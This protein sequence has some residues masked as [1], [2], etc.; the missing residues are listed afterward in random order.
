MRETLYEHG[1]KLVVIKAGFDAYVRYEY[2]NSE[3]EP[4]DLSGLLPELLQHGW[5][6]APLPEFQLRDSDGERTTVAYMTVDLGE[7]GGV[8][9]FEGWGRY[10]FSAP[11]VGVPVSASEVANVAMRGLMALARLMVDD[12]DSEPDPETEPDTHDTDDTEPE[13]SD[14]SDAPPTEPTE[15]VQEVGSDDDQ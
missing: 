9:V 13:D 12:P 1:R 5:A 8:T 6:A 7:G 11:S 15:L 14:S 3:K 10:G 4:L 2:P